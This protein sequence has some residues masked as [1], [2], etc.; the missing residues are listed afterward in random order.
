M[1]SPRRGTGH[2]EPEHDTMAN[3]TLLEGSG[4]RNGHLIA[5]VRCSN[6]ENW[7]GGSMDFSGST[8][9]WIYAAHSGSSLDTS[10]LNASIQQHQAHGV[11]DW[12]FSAARG[13]SSSNPF[14]QNGQLVATP[15]PGEAN[16]GAETES[17]GGSDSSDAMVTAHGTLAAIVFLVLFPG[18][19][20]LIR[21]P[22]RGGMVWVHAG[23]QILAY[24]SFVAAAGL[25]IYLATTQ[26]R[27][28]RTHPLIGM[29]LLAILFFQP[30]AGLLHHYFYKKERRRT[31]VSY[32][33]VYTGRT[34]II[35]GMVNGGLGLKLAGVTNMGFL[36]A[37][38][39]VAGVI[40]VAYLSVI[41][42]SELRRSDSGRREGHAETEKRSRGHA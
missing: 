31:L 23:V 3:V 29:V 18:G 35:L 1:L 39:V 4:V 19:A 20:F 38:G 5:N 13:G 22:R 30:F 8:G 6:C 33:H 27:L 36:A 26:N 11:F 16:G 34:A 40:G 21:T 41:V 32:L 9:S 28:T 12:N 7:Q 25:G 17:K 42:F 24:C 37:Y 10:D 14:V 15:N 2:V